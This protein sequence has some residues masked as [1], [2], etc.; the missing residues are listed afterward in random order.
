MGSG[1][2]NV[3]RL[4]APDES[5][6]W[7]FPILLEDEHYLAL[8]KMTHMAVSHSSSFPDRPSLS[9]LIQH[10][11]ATQARWATKRDIRHLGFAY[12]IDFETSGI[13]LF[14]CLT[15][16]LK[17]L[18]IVLLYTVAVVVALSKFTLRG[19]IAAQCLLDPLGKLITQIGAF[20][21]FGGCLQR[22]G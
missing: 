11:I 17:R 10:A 1:G 3:I 4:F 13:A 19:G 18:G 22:H 20:L 5:H 14:C 15:V 16:Q 8:D 12:R 6:S 7:V 2:K 9:N 21:V